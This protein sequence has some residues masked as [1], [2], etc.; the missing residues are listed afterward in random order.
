MSSVSC[1]GDT[2]Q[3][4]PPRG[5]F[6]VRCQ[7]K[8]RGDEKGPRKALVSNPFSLRLHRKP[9][10]GAESKQINVVISVG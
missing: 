10:G 4:L 7:G 9:P 3:E 1:H 8:Y 6:S 2:E 5:R